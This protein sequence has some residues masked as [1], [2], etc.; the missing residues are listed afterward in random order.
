MG[1]HKP[2]KS[3]VYLNGE[4]FGAVQRTDRVRYTY[5]SAGKS[6][7]NLVR[8][9]PQFGEFVRLDSFS[10]R[11]KAPKTAFIIDATH[12]DDPNLGL[13]PLSH[14]L[15]D[16]ETVLED[17][18]DLMDEDAAGKEITQFTYEGMNLLRDN[19]ELA[20]FPRQS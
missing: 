13:N 7:R 16:S 3:E 9:A 20:G 4:L 2:A 8:A 12:D 10:G 14:V 18:R 11:Y 5:Q 19:G 1:G 17:L 6:F 15:A